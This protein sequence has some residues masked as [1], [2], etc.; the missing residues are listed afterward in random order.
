MKF[1]ITGKEPHSKG[2]LYKIRYGAVER[3]V[4]F[5]SHST[6]RMKKWGI[7]ESMVIETLVK[8]E[9]V[10]TG[11][12]GRFI[13]HRRYKDHLVRAVYEYD[14]F[15][16]VLVTVYFPYANRYFKGGSLYEDKIF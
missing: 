14:R 6:E 12:R 11:H 3:E 7:T 16:P 5:L 4:L 8:P 9:E 15:L 13:A 10:M 1:Q 2:I